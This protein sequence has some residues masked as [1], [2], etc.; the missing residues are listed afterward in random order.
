MTK[1]E[2]Q[3]KKTRDRE[4]TRQ[5][6]LHAAVKVFATQG[7]EG[8][9]TR[10]IADEAGVAE[11]LIQRYF[12]GKQGLLNASLKDFA[13]FE[14]LSCSNLPPP[15]PTL[16]AEWK[17]LLLSAVENCAHNKQNLN[18]AMSQATFDRNF[19]RSMAKFLES[20]RAPALAERL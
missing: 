19:G 8:A 6:L 13:D 4:A 20:N 10:A 1:L 5:K 7:Y 17:S 2:L 3:K 15:V 16:D 18:V 14:K 9:T 12:N 11:A